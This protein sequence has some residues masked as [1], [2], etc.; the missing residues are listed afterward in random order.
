[1]QRRM[2]RKLTL[3]RLLDQLEPHPSPKP[4]LEQYTIPANLAAEILY[5]AAYTYNSITGKTVLD[6]GCGTGRLAIGA[7][8]LGA[9]QA[10]GVDIDVT[11]I[12]MAKKN[13]EKTRLK[14][15]TQWII[16]EINAIKGNF[17]TVLQNPPFGVQARKADTKF[18]AKA[19][20]LGK[21][22]FSLH[23]RGVDNKPSPFLIKFIKARGGTIKTVYPMKMVIPYMFKFHRKQK[24]EFLVDLY[25]IEK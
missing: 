18:L 14:K 19:L 12:Q 1:M 9:K 4:D 13:S 3:E 10:I 21:I 2:V 22:V 11:A 17:D 5:L 16:T 8:F 7:A 23:K 15:K 25:V 24:H 20:E 6:L